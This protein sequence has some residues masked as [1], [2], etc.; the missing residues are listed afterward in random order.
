M[1]NY[2]KY[3]Y[4]CKNMSQPKPYNT[5]VLFAGRLFQ[6]APMFR[7]ALGVVLGIL[8][9]EY[10]PALPLWLLCLAAVLGLG[11]M[12]S[13]TYLVRSRWLFTLSLWLT[14]AAVGWVL[15]LLHAP[16]DPF[17]GQSQLSN[18]ALQV[19]L[20][21]TPRPT[22]KGYQVVAEVDS[23]NG[24][25]TRGRLMLFMAQDTLV[26]GLKA[27]DC[28]RL[29]AS[30]RQPSG[31]EN[32]AQFDYRRYLRH[33]GILW[34]CYVPQG[35]CQLASH[36]GASIGLR[37]RML[38]LQQRW[39]QQLVAF[40][41]TPRQR[42]IA[43]ALLLGWRADVDEDTQQRFRQAGI[44]HLLCVS[45]LHVG[46]LAL[47]VGGLLFFLG[48]RR[49]QRIVKG[50]V[51][52]VAV[53]FFVLLTGMAPATLRAGVMFSLMILGS[54]AGRRTSTLNNLATSAL[55]ILS[56]APMQ[57]FDVGF[58]LSYAALLGILAWQ[59]PLQNLIPGLSERNSKPHRWLLSKV[60]GW[61]CLS[62]AAQVGTLP[63]VLY[64]FHQF[65]LYFLIANLSVVPFAG[66]LLAT[67]LLTVL[68][69]GGASITALLRWELDLV[70]GLTRW[71]S[72]LPSAL[73]EDLYCDLP[74]ALLLVLALLLCTCW[75]RGHL[76]WALPTSV[77]CLLVAAIYVWGVNHQAAR[78]RDV[79]VYHAGRYLAVECVQGRHSY[80]VCDAAVA[81]NPH[82]IDYQRSGY[83]LR[84]RISSST[85]LPIDTTY[86]DPAC[87]VRHHCILFGQQKIL[88]IDST[89][90]APF[91]RHA[92]A[93]PPPI[94]LHLDAVVI[95]PRTQ[96]DT[97]R[98]RPLLSFATLHY[99]SY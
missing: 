28:L 48:R 33:Q 34:Q 90:A 50:A 40:P 99:R 83:L 84:R 67:T 95:A 59:R 98:L 79:V 21:Q 74:L 76:R 30:P 20:R 88:V 92:G 44:T 39:A 5:L 91:R 37:Y 47:L 93:Q 53:W 49:W 54:M 22:A 10:L 94:H 8:L 32:P 36:P 6:R 29:T 96:L 4:F 58:Q 12:A 52:L 69:G 60:W 57:L 55:L 14:F 64:Y 15:V 61:T 26:A 41:L 62:T 72:S 82:L 86:S 27:G 51:Q 46:V 23:V 73:L 77:A 97:S 7:V 80:L 65:P 3:L 19:R 18:S 71:V 24:A 16:A 25:P 85:V 68:S 42:G 2:E 78:G 43:Q 31:A 63:L 38:W 66:V 89:N 56:F 81:R 70:D 45:G 17:A 11:L 13:A 35:S 9:G 87:V 1:Q 75:L